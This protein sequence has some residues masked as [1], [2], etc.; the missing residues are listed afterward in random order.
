MHRI[1]MV[2]EYIGTDFA[3]F[4]IQPNKRTVQGE[5]ETALTRLLGENIKIYASGR[6]DAGVHALGQV[7]HFDTEVEIDCKH[8]LYQL[9][10]VGFRDITIREVCEV[11]NSFDARFSVKIKTYSY[12]FYLSRYERVMYKGRALRVND[13]VDV[14]KMKQGL[15]GLVGTFDF[16]SFVARKCQKTDFVRTIYSV[17]IN[18]VGDGLYEFEISGNGFLY[19]MVR[20]IMGTLIDMGAGR[21][22]PNTMSDIILAKN[23]TKAGKTVPPYGLYMKSVKYDELSV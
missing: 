15:K 9:N 4:Q 2:F 17:K 21:K 23:R 3:G 6:T 12:L 11:D 5:I 16:T 22:N 8:L 19:N 20:I 10:N 7:A 14:E 13:N 1:V 18:E